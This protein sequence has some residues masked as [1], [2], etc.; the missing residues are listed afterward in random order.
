MVWPAFLSSLCGPWGGP[1]VG[2]IR[3]ET[4]NVRARSAASACLPRRPAMLCPAPGF[5]PERAPWCAKR[6]TP[7]LAWDARGRRLRSG[8]GRRAARGIPLPQSMERA[9]RIHNA[10]CSTKNYS[11]YCSLTGWT[12]PPPLASRKK[13]RHFSAYFG[14]LLEG[15]AWRGSPTGVL[16][17]AGGGAPGRSRIR[18]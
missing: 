4:Q 15:V 10:I 16:S 1:N 14:F 13:V 12:A 9:A 11:I 18:C 2:Q 5:E 3:D 17:S 6:G 7:L 8:R